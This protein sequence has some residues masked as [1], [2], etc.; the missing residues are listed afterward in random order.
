[1]KP[2]AEQFQEMVRDGIGPDLRM[3]GFQG[4]GR[5]FNWPSEYYYALLG[6]QSRDAGD[7]LT[8]EFTANVSVIDVHGWSLLREL[9]P[10]FPTKPRSNVYYSVPNDP[11]THFIWQRRIGDLVPEEEVDLWWLLRE[12]RDWHDVARSVVEV[13]RD[14]VLPEFQKR[15]TNPSTG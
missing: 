11:R 5:N 14:F 10:G 15:A 6:F 8:F 2:V 1:V 3:L 9:Y 13:V 12:G 4:S 7:R